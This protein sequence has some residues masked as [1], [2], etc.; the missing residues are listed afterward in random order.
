MSRNKVCLPSI[1]GVECSCAP[2]VGPVSALHGA[3][4]ING[5]RWT[6]NISFLYD[7]TRDAFCTLHSIVANMYIRQ[8]HQHPHERRFGA[9]I[10]PLPTVPVLPPCLMIQPHPFG[11]EIV[12]LY[13]HFRCSGVSAYQSQ[14]TSSARHHHE[15]HLLSISSSAISRASPRQNGQNTS[16]Q[17]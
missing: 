9:I 11:L 4:R 14:T 2:P 15:Q 16:P 5:I 13:Y 12:P 17:H 7:D 10:N 8:M 6:V 3:T 1:T